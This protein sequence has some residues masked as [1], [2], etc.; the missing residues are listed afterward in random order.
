MTL[1]DSHLL[2]T[3]SCFLLLTSPSSMSEF[4]RLF[5]PVFELPLFDPCLFL[6]LE[7][8]SE[9]LLLLLECLLFPF[10]LSSSSF[11]MSPTT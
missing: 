7:L 9:L 2:I 1:L 11:F 6:F 3:Q 4:L 10:F 5:L 8:P